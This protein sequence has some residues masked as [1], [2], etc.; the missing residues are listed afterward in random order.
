M[1]AKEMIDK[2]K[3]CLI[4]GYD[5]D[6]ITQEEMSILWNYITNL[7]DTLKDREEYCYGLET[8]L[9]NLQEENEDL[10]KNQRYYKNGVFSLEYDKETLSDMVDDYKSRI[11]KAI[12]YM[13]KNFVGSYMELRF[14]LL[15]GDSD[16]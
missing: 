15:G 13:D 11:E 7:Q 5:L 16:E 1:S 6:I 14:L 12:E 2:I 9:T 10:R 3:K 8:Q 4:G